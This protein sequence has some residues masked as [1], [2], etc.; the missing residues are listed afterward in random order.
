VNRNIIN[1]RRWPNECQLAFFLSLVIG[2]SIGAIIGTREAA[3]WFGVAMWIVG[4]GLY[5]AAAVYIMQLLK[6]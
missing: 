4:G 6:A 3:S 5:S 2:G 1:P